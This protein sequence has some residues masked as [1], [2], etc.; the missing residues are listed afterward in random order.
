MM[1][2]REKSDPA[3]VAVKPANEAERSAAEPGEPRAGTK[4]N[5]DQ[6]STPRTP[7]RTSVT[8]ALERIRQTAKER[9]KE[10]FTALLHHITPELLEAEF[11]ALKEHAAPGVDGMR[12]RDYE[13]N[14][15]SNLDELHARVHRGAYQ[16]LP[17]RRVYIPK[18]DG[19]QRPLAVVGPVGK[20]G[21]RGT[22][23]VV[24]GS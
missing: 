11:F 16:P 4:G 22:R 24:N 18:S 12:W 14:L 13:Q 23:T 8:H 2:E 1:H 9:K 21:Q 5:A 10:R 20:I 15:R 19:R 3:I 17:S 6:H 7:S